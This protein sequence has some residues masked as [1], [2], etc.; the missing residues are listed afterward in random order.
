MYRMRM[1]AGHH[2]PWR[3]REEPGRCGP[4]CSRRRTGCVRSLQ[5]SNGCVDTP[6]DDLNS[7]LPPITQAGVVEGVSVVLLAG[8]VGKRMKADRPKQFLEL[9]G[10][11]VLLHSLDIFSTLPGVDRCA[12]AAGCRMMLC[13]GLSARCLVGNQKRRHRCSTTIIPT[14]H[15]CEQR[16]QH[17]DRAGQ[18]VQTRLRLSPGAG[19]AHH[20]CR[21][22]K[23][24]GPS[25][26]RLVYWS[27]PLLLWHALFCLALTLMLPDGTGSGRTRCSTASARPRRTPPS[28]ASTTRRGR[29]S[30]R[31]PSSP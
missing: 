25:H 29:S 16:T 28:C 8:G 15:A 24:S 6:I 3:V 9:L 17:R 13:A 30:R 22:G 14:K 18:V 7:S 20:L 23:V 11:P 27:F 2:Q 31:R 5:M 12:R 4:A 26:V 19:P 10:K 1:R 21:P